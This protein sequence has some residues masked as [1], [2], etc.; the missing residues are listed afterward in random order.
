MSFLFTTFSLVLG[1][2]FLRGNIVFSIIVSIAY[3]AFLLFR[4]GKKKFVLFAS[5]FA[6][7]VLIP[8]IPFPSQEGNYSGFVVEARE[9]YIIYQAG[10]DRYYV[11][12]KENDFELGDYLVCDG[13][14]S[15]IK[16]NTYESQ[17]NFKEY[18]TNK[19][20][21]KE[22]KASNIDRK[23]RSFIRTQ[24]F[25]RNF[26]SHFDENAAS[27]IGAFL[28]NEKDYSSSAINYANSIGVI[29]LLS[30]SGIYLHLLFSVL[31]Y[32]LSLKFS[33][34]TS[35]ILPF[36]ILLPFAFFSFTKI[37]T[38]RVYALYLLKYLNDYHFKKKRSHIELVS[39]L[40]LIF[41]IVDYHLV[42]Q[43]AFYIG[44]SLSILAPFI[45]NSLKLVNKKKRKLA[46]M[47]TVRLFMIPIQVNNGCINLLSTFLYLL[48]FPINFFFL[49]ISMFAIIIPFYGF[50][51]NVGNGLTWVLEKMDLINIKIPFGNWGGYFGILFYSVFFFGIFLL[52]SGRKMSLKKLT[53]FSIVCFIL[54]IVPLQEPLLNSI[55]FINVGQGDS[56]LIKNKTHTVM[57]DTGGQ[58]SFDMAEETLIPFMNK[59][60]ITHIDALIT[61]H[62][63]FDHSGAKD[64]LINKFKVYNYLNKPE[65]FPYKIGDIYLENLNVFGGK[66]DNDKS[67]VLSMNFMK[68]KWLFMGD[69]STIVEKEI[70]SAYD[71]I[72]CDII[73]LGHHG[74][75]TS[76]CNEF[77]KATTPNEAII[78]VG[79]KN[80]YGHPNQ[81]VIDILNR[82]NVKIRRTDE[83]GTI[84]YFS[85]FT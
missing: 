53:I 64:S 59:N 78:S 34:K 76:T 45:Q 48:I 42:Y 71:S 40:A 73:K 30:M 2:Y 16:F 83:E 11:S 24:Q 8:R 54:S 1:L 66:D 84:S 12:S 17:F 62:D 43:E 21:D 55:S 67:L 23:F 36:L 9:N 72:D 51:N 19:G 5:M 65:Q 39:V 6:I 52:E 47:M 7:G 35:Q 37:G 44:F 20:V 3:L 10:F 85:L 77:I 22:L 70:I 49:L 56:I 80:Y 61:T 25:K 33:K 69:A 41:I 50:V 29:Y 27:L 74:S 38:L 18:L 75:K 4:F 26:L 46:Y 82:N 28:F 13:F 32:L 79:A 57:I 14:V 60:K 31:A 68:K 58:R 15:E 81:E 63:D